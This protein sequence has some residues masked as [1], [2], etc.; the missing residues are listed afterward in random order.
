MQLVG[1]ACSFRVDIQS[2]GTAR[3][4]SAVRVHGARAGRRRIYQG[5]DGRSGAA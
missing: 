2:V 3:H 1:A 5:R 4:Y